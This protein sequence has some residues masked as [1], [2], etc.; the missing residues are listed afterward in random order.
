MKVCDFG[1]A[2]LVAR[3]QEQ[4]HYHDL[5][6][7]GRQSPGGS[8]ITSLMV[9]SGT[10]PASPSQTRANGNHSSTTIGTYAWCSPEVL[11]DSAHSFA[12][13]VYR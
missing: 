4:P 13:D 8:S 5:D 9:N 3:M 10:P 2:S 7:S 12:S 1:T 11:R 6:M